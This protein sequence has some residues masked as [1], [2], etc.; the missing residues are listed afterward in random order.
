[1]KYK[2][3]KD[4]NGVFIISLVLL[5]LVIFL[6][7]G[8]SAFNSTL[9]V[10]SYLN[11]RI[12]REIRI[13]NFSYVSNTN[14]ASSRYEDYNTTSVTA[15]AVFPNENA[16]I[17]YEVE[18]TNMQLPSGV[19]MGIYNISGLPE[20]LI[21]VGNPTGYTLKTKLCDNNDPTDCGSGAQKTFQL[22]VGCVSATYCNQNLNYYK[23]DLNFDFRVMHMVTYSGIT[24]YSTQEII[25][26]DN[27]IVDF[28]SNAPNAINVS[29]TSPYVLNTDYT[30]TNGILTVQN[31]TENITVTGANGNGTW[32][33]PYVD[34]VVQVY[35]PDP[36]NSQLGTTRYDSIPGKPKVTV[37]QVGNNKV[38]TAFEYTDIGANGMTLS[39]A[40]NTGIL[41]FQGRGFRIQARYSLNSSNNGNKYL[42]AALEQTGKQGNNKLYQGFA[43][44]IYKSSQIYLSASSTGAKFG[45]TWGSQLKTITISTGLKTYEVDL[46]YDSGRLTGTFFPNSRN[47]TE[48]IDVSGSSF[49]Q[50]LANATITLGGNGI[51]TTHNVSGITIYEFSVTP[52]TRT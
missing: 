38:V 44:Y 1:M 31:V 50:T 52:Y 2:R 27:L 20:G 18:V 16:T 28:G 8:W 30:Y 11:I 51:D 17:T 29:G 33:S 15:D 45:N 37:E 41:A 47:T 35:N 26:G 10:G 42:L 40:L 21:L 14:N 39:G 25:D 12:N 3:K 13:T 43:L 22:T 19:N 7:I 34:T 48:N 46:Q 24:G 5:F 32:S 23:F 49:P 6:T 9:N 4:F 36:T